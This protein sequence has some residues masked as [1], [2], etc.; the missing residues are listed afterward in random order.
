MLDQLTQFDT[1]FSVSSII[2]VVV[3]VKAYLYT[4]QPLVNAV[5]PQ[6]AALNS[7]KEA[8]KPVMKKDGDF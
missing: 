2:L 5:A 4:M 8:L 7:H 6:A 3:K 1:D